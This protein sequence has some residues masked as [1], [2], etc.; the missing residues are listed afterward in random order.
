MEQLKFVIKCQ[1]IIEF[2]EHYFTDIKYKI[3][4]SKFKDDWTF[5]IVGTRNDYGKYTGKEVFWVSEVA[6]S[7]S[8][9]NLPKLLLEKCQERVKEYVQSGINDVQVKL[10]ELNKAKSELDCRLVIQ[11]CMPVID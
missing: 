2:M 8:L 11:K 1:Q 3:E 7:E 10:N 4:F 9:S 6:K 5:R